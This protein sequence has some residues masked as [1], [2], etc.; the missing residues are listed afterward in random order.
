MAFTFQPYTSPLTASIADRLA[1]QGAIEA[2]RA[3][4]TGN[5]AANAALQSG[6][7][8]SGAIQGVGQAIGA[9]PGQIAAGQA[10]EQNRAIRAQQ[11]QSGA[12]QLGQA[13]RTEQ[14]A[15]LLD[16]YRSR[17]GEL[18]NNPAN[19]NEDGTLN[20]DGLAGQ[21]ATLPGGAAGPA[22]PVDRELLASVVHPIN[23]DITDA[24]TAKLAWEEKQTNALARIAGTA[25]TL[26]S[27]DGNFVGHAQLGLA[28]ALRGGLINQDQANQFLVPMVEHPEAVP[29]QL[30][31]I[32]ARST[33]APIKLGK[34][35]TLV[36]AVMPG[37]VLAKGAEGPPTEAEL[38][39]KAAGGDPNATRAMALLKPPPAPRPLNE[40]LLEAIAN[41]DTTKA[42]QITQTLKT[43]AAA[44]RD[45]DAAAMARELGGLR[46]DE[47]RARLAAL[48]TT[49]AAKA[50]GKPLPATEADKISEID[51]GLA[52][53]RDLRESL[54]TGATG[55]V[56]RAKATLV[57]N[58]L[59]NLVPGAAEAKAT[60]ADIVRA[61]QVVG[62]IIHGGV[63]R[64]NDQA[65]AGKYMPQL[66]DAPSVIQSKL[67]AVEQ[68]ATEGRATHLGN[69]GKSG[70]NVSQFATAD[71]AAPPPKP[72][73][74]A[75]LAPGRTQRVVQNGVT[76]DV[77]TDAQ[78]RLVSSQ[79]VR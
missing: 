62:R 70:Y 34:D 12:L 74:H 73:P 5:A 47:A 22:P 53:V 28:A 41:G 54:S 10:A 33:A 14:R 2:Q 24:R 37:Q 77:V 39:L 60:Q 19:F 52:A 44:G 61:Q 11:L 51:K 40:Q 69:L 48:A 65:A 20:L 46:A 4:A 16:Q 6:N 29:G 1:Q 72:P 21:M 63:L 45:P 36:S 49:A 38:A 35:D 9:L 15:S 30:Q 59:A 17:V 57:P 7:A 23:Q 26:G 32:A 66:D 25:Y 13:Q 50:E 31:S 56:A 43:A 18:A 79:V 68:M 55:G 64:A 27:K 42:S 71:T 67:D 78:G 75:T 76:Y 8:W 3:Y 58:A